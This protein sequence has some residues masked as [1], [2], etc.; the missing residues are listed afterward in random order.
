MVYNPKQPTAALDDRSY[1]YPHTWPPPVSRP[2]DSWTDTDGLGEYARTSPNGNAAVLAD[3]PA[4]EIARA[5]IGDA[6]RIPVVWCQFG[7]CIGRFTDADALGESDVRSRAMAAGWRQDALGRLACPECV[8]HDPTF[9][10]VYPLGS[11]RQSW[12]APQ[13]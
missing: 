9:R 4:Q 11:R 5:V 3:H 13:S 10:V 7:A 8:Q 1:L 6:L 2:L 12:Q